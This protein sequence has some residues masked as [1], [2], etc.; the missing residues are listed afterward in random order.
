MGSFGFDASAR[1]AGQ[2]KIT[3][4]LVRI[5]TEQT[6]GSPITAS[7]TLSATGDGVWVA[8]KLSG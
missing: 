1:R 6:T 4:V 7:F 8:A 2:P 3:G 5:L